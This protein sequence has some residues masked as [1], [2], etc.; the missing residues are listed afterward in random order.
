[1]RKISSVFA[2]LIGFFLLFSCG[3]GKMSEN[4]LQELKAKAE[5]G[6]YEAARQLTDYYG[7]ITMPLPLSEY[8]ALLEKPNKSLWLHSLQKLWS[9]VFFLTCI[10]PLRI[11][12]AD[13]KSV[14]PR[15]SAVTGRQAN[16]PQQYSTV[17]FAATGNFASSLFLGLFS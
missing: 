13:F 6:N 9:C 1:M 5:K 8:N 7:N 17:T 3:S 11:V 14:A 10:L 12:A 15:T 16:L 2:V 4:D